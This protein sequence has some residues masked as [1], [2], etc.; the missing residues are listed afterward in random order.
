VTLVGGAESAA[1]DDEAADWGLS[2]RTLVEA[3]GRACADAFLRALDGRGTRFSRIAVLAGSGN[4]AADALVMLRVLLDTNSSFFTGRE[5]RVFLSKACGGDEQ[6]P[7][8][9]ALAALKKMGTPVSVW[10]GAAELPTPD[11]LII[12]GV[13]GSGIRGALRGTALE[14]TNAVNAVKARPPENSVIVSIDVPSGARDSMEADDPVLRCD[15]C[16]AVEPLKFCCYTPRVRSAIGRVIPVTGIFPGELLAK[17]RSGE[18]LDWKE[19]AARVMP[20]PPDAHKYRRGVVEIRAGCALSAG[21]GRIAAAGAAAAGAGLVRLGVDESIYP[22]LAANAGAMVYP[23]SQSPGF[24]EGR[25]KADAILLGPGWGRED[26]RLP[27]LREALA[28]E[29][30]GVPL[31]LDADAIALASGAEFNGNTL[32]TP[33]TGEL[34]AFCGIPKERLLSDPRIVEKIAREKNAVIL[35]KSPV[36][37]IA[38]GTRMIVVD[39]MNAAL[40]AGGTGDL[41]AGFCA[42]LAARCR[43]GGET[44]V[45]ALASCAAAA[46]ALLVEAARRGGPQ[47]FDPLDL[48]PLAA[49]AA[50][51][52][53]LG[54]L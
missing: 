4:N 44:G 32:L 54:P 12:D 25:F 27:V 13:C 38:G 36:M 16:L 40:G 47:F 31:V 24:R 43:A 19:A 52:A 51:E 9:S 34:A 49:A 29:K 41:L 18:L 15:Y 21:A 10:D 2:P 42:A 48:V 1:L 14:M 53:W 17:Y 22:V 45:E 46:A 30:A 11:T 39:G 5:A 3:A 33:H 26:A 20:P 6:S 23:A 7:R 28:A 50:G 35:F 37:I 8:A